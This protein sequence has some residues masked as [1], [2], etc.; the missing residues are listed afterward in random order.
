MCVLSL[1]TKA[2]YFYTQSCQKNSQLA[3]ASS[4]SATLIEIVII[5]MQLVLQQQRSNMAY[6]Q[7]PPLDKTQDHAHQTLSPLN[8]APPTTLTISGIA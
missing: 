1:K 2:K 7:V 5:L 4:R 6:S 8:F 3:A